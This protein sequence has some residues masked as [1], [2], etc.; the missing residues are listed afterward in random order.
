VSPD[1]FYG[2]VKDARFQEKFIMYKYDPQL[3]ITLQL[4]C[5]EWSRP[6]SRKIPQRKFP[7]DQELFFE[8]RERISPRAL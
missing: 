4:M 5:E 6:A 7:G 8:R 3:V 2:A 1:L